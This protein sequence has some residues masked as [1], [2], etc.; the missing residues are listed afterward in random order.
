M[1]AKEARKKAEEVSTKKNQETINYIERLI[2][3]TVLKGCF[4]CNYYKS[5]NDV[6][7]TYFKN[8]GFQVF[9]QEEGRNEYSYTISW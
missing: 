1:D 3:E 9:S 6:V 7:K 5:L 8:K 2:Q 4:K